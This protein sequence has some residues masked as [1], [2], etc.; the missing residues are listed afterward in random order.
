MRNAHAS[1]A[2]HQI[3]EDGALQQE[4]PDDVVE[5]G[6]GDFGQIIRG[7]VLTKRGER[8]GMHQ[9]GRGFQIPRA[10]VRSVRR[11]LSS[12]P[13]K[14]PEGA[15]GAGATQGGSTKGGVEAVRL[16][17]VL[18]HGYTGGAAVWGGDMVFLAP[19]AQRLEG[20]YVVF[21][22]QVTKLKSKRERNGLC[23]KVATD[24]LLQGAGTQPL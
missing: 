14:H 9:G 10:A 23:R 16:G 19:T 3:P 22:R 7:N 5:K 13:T 15:V 2:A 4:H 11:K 20:V 8:G 24:N 18:S 6:C 1:G 17:K 21:L 12:S